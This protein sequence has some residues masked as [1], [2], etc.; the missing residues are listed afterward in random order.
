MTIPQ[1][2]AITGVGVVC[3]IG[4]GTTA[5]WDSLSL[6][7]S[8]VQH[9]HLYDGCTEL[10]V[11]FGGAVADFDAKQYVRPRK[12]LKVMCRDI[13][14]AFA[15][16]DLACVD[17][18]IQQRRIDPERLGVVF[19]ADMMN[20]DAEEM[21]AAYRGCMDDGKFAFARWGQSAMAG[22][23]P[24]TM[25]KYLPNM[26]ACHVGIAQDARGHNNTIV[27]GDVSSLAAV[28][29][30]ARVLQRGR[31]DVIIAGGASTRIHPT[32][33]IRSQ[34]LAFSRRSDETAAACRPFDAR[35]PFCWR[36]SPMP[37]PAARPY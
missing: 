36:P 28:A 1:E 29:E 37:R 14:L 30:A 32:L 7:R 24:L 31:A 13:Q 26:A 12:S 35:R 19:G 9:L 17:G 27:L 11:P 8:G 10:P 21:I 22:L 33:W 23:Y 18:G 15:A 34:I 4:I 5:Y 25:L 6:G 3:P 20:C 2:I 16:A